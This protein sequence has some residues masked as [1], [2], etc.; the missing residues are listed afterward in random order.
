MAAAITNTILEYQ[1][2]KLL[3]IKLQHYL[4]LHQKKRHQNQV[5]HRKVPPPL[6]C[7]ILGPRVMARATIQRYEVACYIILSWYKTG[8]NFILFYIYIYIQEQEISLAN[9]IIEN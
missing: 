5:H 4:L 7:L 6:M 1:N 2:Q 8:F 3:H 9:K